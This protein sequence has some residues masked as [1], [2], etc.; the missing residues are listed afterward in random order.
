MTYKNRMGTAKQ[1]AGMVLILAIVVVILY[2][3]LKIFGGQ[4]AQLKRT[5]HVFARSNIRPLASQKGVCRCA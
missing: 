2:A 5:C 3:L 1:T 4:N